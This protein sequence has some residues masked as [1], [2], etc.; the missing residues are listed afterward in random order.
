MS[1]AEK[2]QKGKSQC[3]DTKTSSRGKASLA[4]RGCKRLP[5]TFGDPCRIGG[6]RPS[7]NDPGDQTPR[8]RLGENG[9]ANACLMFALAQQMNQRMSA[10][11]TDRKRGIGWLDHQLVSWSACQLL[12]V[13]TLP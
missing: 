9:M 13:E 3:R 4:R 11:G 6:A 8:E 7:S 10:S 1:P 2:G 12:G 5:R